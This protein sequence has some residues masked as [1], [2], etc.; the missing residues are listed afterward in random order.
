MLIWGKDYNFAPDFLFVQQTDVLMKKFVL[1][2]I[3]LIG[4]LKV[5]ADSFS[6]LTFETT[7]GEKISVAVDESLTLTIS[8]T[9]LTSGS[10]SFSLSNLSKMYF[11]NTDETTSIRETTDAALEEAVTIYNLQGHKVS[12][13]QMRKG[14][15][16]IR[17]KDKTYKLIVK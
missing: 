1:L 9:T 17:T 7:D 2:L 8:G 13:G 12:K 16:I 11:S 6:F 14:A 4:T 10:E 5:R 3:V 15:Y